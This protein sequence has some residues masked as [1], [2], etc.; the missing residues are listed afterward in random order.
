[1]PAIPP[2]PS[3]VTGPVGDYLQVLWKAIY[4]IPNMSY[5]SGSDPNGAVD[6]VPGDLVVNAVSSTS[7][8]RLYQ[9]GGSTRI[10][11]NTGWNLV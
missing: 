3:A 9:K 2:P 5:F 8:L 10:K 1:M 7:N 11:S 4:S 6:G